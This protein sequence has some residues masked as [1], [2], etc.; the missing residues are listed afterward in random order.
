M[1]LRAGEHSPYCRSRQQQPDWRAVTQCPLRFVANEFVRAGAMF[2]SPF[3]E[4]D[5]YVCLTAYRSY[6]RSKEE[7]RLRLCGCGGAPLGIEH[8]QG[9]RHPVLRRLHQPTPAPG[10]RRASAVR[11]HSGPAVRDALRLSIAPY[12]TV[13]MR[14]LAAAVGTTPMALYTHPRSKRCSTAL[15]RYSRSSSSRLA[16]ASLDSARGPP[17][18][19]AAPASAHPGW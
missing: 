3:D 6:L 15:R 18:A 19:P 9:T 13:S 7:S 16:T 17:R 10:R 8:A 11:D 1:R 14:L 5:G 4:S 12:S 2:N